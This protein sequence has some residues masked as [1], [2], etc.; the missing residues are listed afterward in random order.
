MVWEAVEHVLSV[1]TMTADFGAWLC[2]QDLRESQNVPRIFREDTTATK[3]L[4]RRAAASGCF[5][6]AL[7]EPVNEMLASKTGISDTDLGN[8]L[9]AMARIFRAVV[10]VDLP[11]DLCVPLAA[12]RDQLILQNVDPFSVLGRL[13]MLRWVSPLLFASVSNMSQEKIAWLKNA[14]KILISIGEP[15]PI[16]E[17]SHLFPFNTWVMSVKDQLNFFLESACDSEKIAE[18]KRVMFTERSKQTLRAKLRKQ[19]SF[20]EK[21]NLLKSS[22]TTLSEA[23][24]RVDWKEILG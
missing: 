16:S 3:W 17:E 1:H 7:Q 8:A 15:A 18:K 4:G 5:R 6:E 12:A 11:L 9:L 21:L 14:A 2:V 24:E 23:V 19:R 13:V 20:S 10:S 22:L